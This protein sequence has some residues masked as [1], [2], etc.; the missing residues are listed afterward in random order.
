MDKK[1]IEKLNTIIKKTKKDIEYIYEED[2]GE[3][4]EDNEVSKALEILIDKLEDVENTIQYYCRPTK[5]GHL[6]LDNSTGK[7]KVAFLDGTSSKE[8]IIGDKLELY[9]I[10]DGWKAGTLEH[11]TEKCYYFNNS[12][13]KSPVIRQDMK[14]RIRVMV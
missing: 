5:E 9:V 8:T 12:E 13:I 7:Y 2:P 6:V 1:Y 11:N 4:L 10:G 14:V 3:E